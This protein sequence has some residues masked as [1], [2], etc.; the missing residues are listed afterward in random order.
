M[1]NNDIKLFFDIE[2]RGLHITQDPHTG[3]SKISYKTWTFRKG[4]LGLIKQ[5]YFKDPVE[6]RLSLEVIFNLKN[7]DHDKLMST[8][9][10]DLDDLL[11]NIIKPMSGVVFQRTAQIQEM[12]VKKIYSKDEGYI[13][14]NLRKLD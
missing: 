12:M 11:A 1:S 13:M 2:P 6:C 9:R 8:S 4:I 7:K 10:P 5:Q 3:Q 14:I